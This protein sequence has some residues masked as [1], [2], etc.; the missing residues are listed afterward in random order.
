LVEY[1]R[2]GK[3]RL[4][5]YVGVQGF[6]GSGVLVTDLIAAWVL[7]SHPEHESKP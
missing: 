7:V 5:S 6:R 1:S 4:L 3:T 2:D